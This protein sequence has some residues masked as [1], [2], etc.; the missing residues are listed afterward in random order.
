MADWIL[1]LLGIGAVLIG[2]GLMA[3]AGFLFLK[4]GGAGK[5]IASAQKKLR[6]SYQSR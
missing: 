5:L 3:V 1:I 2:L 4:L 6:I